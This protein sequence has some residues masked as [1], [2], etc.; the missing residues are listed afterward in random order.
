MCYY[1]VALLKKKHGTGPLEM[2]HFNC[3]KSILEQW[4]FCS[5]KALC[6]RPYEKRT[7]SFAS[8]NQLGNVCKCSTCVTKTIANLA[9]YSRKPENYNDTIIFEFDIMKKLIPNQFKSL[10]NLT[11]SLVVWLF[12]LFW[13]TVNWAESAVSPAEKKCYFG[14]DMAKNMNIKLSGDEFFMMPIS[15]IMLPL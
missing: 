4:N 10:S 13:F 15:K 12:I 7:L 9:T 11:F 5:D 6:P 3:N 2:T 1:P 14:F 8:W